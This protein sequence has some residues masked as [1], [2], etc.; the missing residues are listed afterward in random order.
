VLLSCPLFFDE[1]GFGRQVAKKLNILQNLNTQKFGHSLS[2]KLIS[3]GLV[4]APDPKNASPNYQPTIV[5]YRLTKKGENRAYRVV[6]ED[7]IKAGLSEKEEKA[8]ILV[9]RG[10]NARKLT[11]KE[12]EELSEE[13]GVPKN[14]VAGVHKTLQVRVEELLRSEKGFKPRTITVLVNGVPMQARL[15]VALSSF[16]EEAY[17]LLQSLQAKHLVELTFWTKDYNDHEVIGGKLTPVGDAVSDFV[18]KK[19]TRITE[20]FAVDNR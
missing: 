1:A 4:E 12:V 16:R 10:D 17:G 2:S 19:V 8:L 20:T 6:T 9:S 3:A 13:R 5:E 7:V 11:D 14:E 18:L 15:E